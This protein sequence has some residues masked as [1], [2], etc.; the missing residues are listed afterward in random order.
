[1][2]LGATCGGPQVYVIEVHADDGRV[3][4]VSKS[5]DDFYAFHTALIKQFPEE[6]GLTGRRRTLPDLPAQTI[7]VTEAFAVQQQ[8]DFD[9]YIK[10]RCTPM[11]CHAHDHKP[12][13][14]HTNAR[15]H[16]HVR[17]RPYTHIYVWMHTRMHIL[18]AGC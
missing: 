10:V 11:H 8:R 2:R 6:A 1:M 14:T 4:S 3:F 12:P 9:R 17:A 18:Q 15:T 13:R 16:A 7:H 5:Y